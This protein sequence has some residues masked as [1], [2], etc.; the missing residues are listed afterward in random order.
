MS[1]RRMRAGAL[2]LVLT[3][4]A[5]AC[6]G[7][8][9]ETETAGEDDDVLSSPSSLVDGATTD[10]VAG[11]TPADAA[12]DGGGDAA[13]SGPADGEQPTEG[14]DGGQA[15]APS[16]GGDNGNTGGE[17]APGEAPKGPAVDD[18]AAKSRLLRLEDVGSG[19]EKGE[20]STGNQD[21][22]G[23]DQA[24]EK[25]LSAAGVDPNAVGEPNGQASRQ[26]NEKGGDPQLQEGI[27]SAVAGF[28]D[29]GAPARMTNGLKQLF[30]SAPGRKCIEE[31]IEKAISSAPF[32]PAGATVDVVATQL[33][34]YTAG[35]DIAQLRLKIT[36]T[37]GV[38]SFVIYSD[39][40]VVHSGNFAGIVGLTNAEEP[41]ATAAGQ[42]IVNKALARLA[43]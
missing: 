20:E 9:S 23:F 22:D 1:G 2:A 35:S 15:P 38:Q 36:V 31:E 19:Y 10:D 13:T 41:L 29:A 3:L 21:E 37:V 39:L 16:G 14:G 30:A 40:V 18:A 42:P 25:C 6:G 33:T 4:T 5:A 11:E 34:A 17:P 8:D 28:S 32:F 12:T 43:G 24:F 27:L 7:G 26:F